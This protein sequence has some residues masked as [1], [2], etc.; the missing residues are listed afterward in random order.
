[1][2]A[3][4]APAA[5]VVRTPRLPDL[6]EA[7]PE[8][9]GP[10]RSISTMRVDLAAAPGRSLKEVRCSEVRFEG[11][12]SGD[13]DGRGGRFLETC[14]DGVSAERMLAGGSTWRASQVQ[15][16]RFGTLEL[17]RAELA[18]VG[19]AD[20]K[21]DR[22]NLAG[23]R[24]TDLLVQR[25]RIGE[26]DVSGIGAER[27]AFR[28]VTIGTLTVTGAHLRDVDLRSAHIERIVGVAGLKGA[29]ITGEQLIDLAPALAELLGIGVADPG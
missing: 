21:V 29:T 9:V 3:T 17:D 19:I 1:M 14:F 6:D 16:C 24:A 23:A 15:G 7:M 5:P 2:V 25:C 20:S 26:C 28:D 12:G 4:R 27:V 18:S 10:S 22:L 11:M 13:I 8:D